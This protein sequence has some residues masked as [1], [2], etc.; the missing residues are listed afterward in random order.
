MISVIINVYNGE[1][2]IKR[3]IDSVLAQSFKDYELLLVDDGSTDSTAR[4]IDEYACLRNVKAFH[5]PNK[6]IGG[7][8]N[9]ALTQVSGEYIISLDC[10]DWVENNWLE[11]LYSKMVSQNADMVVCEYYEEYNG[12]QREIKI[13]EYN[14][15]DSF[16]RDLMH[17]KTW[18]VLWNKLIKTEI[19]KKHGLIIPNLTYWEDIPFIVSYLLYCE[20]VAYIHKPLYN[21][22]KT[23]VDSLTFIENHKI[24]FNLCRV[25]AVKIIET[26]LEKTRKQ[27]IFAKDVLWLKFWIK[28][29]FVI[30]I[31][32]KER[33]RLWRN[34]FPEVNKE[35]KMFAGKFSFK[36]WAL[37]HGWDW[38]LLVNGKYWQLRHK[39]K[40]LLMNGK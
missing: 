19:V 30:H 36:Y 22:R 15:I 26:Y 18:G 34:S 23:N 25:E 16:V 9:Y 27:K 33:I 38:Y 24:S 20:K 13:A 29:E 14:E 12:Q 1:K 6:G 28:N 10:D 11:E 3:C 40:A 4:I 17:G 8:R 21:Y 37:Q 31:V 7:S 32:S 5:T 2:Y 39:L 35:W